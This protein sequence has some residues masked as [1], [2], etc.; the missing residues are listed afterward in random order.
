M[1]GAGIYASERKLLVLHYLIASLNL[2]LS[3]YP[4]LENVCDLARLKMGE[5]WA[6]ESVARAALG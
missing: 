4:S 5:V 1:I 2:I 6:R 3:S